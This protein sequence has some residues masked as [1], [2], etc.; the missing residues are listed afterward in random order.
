MTNGNPDIIIID[1]DPMVGELS[2]DLLTDEGYKVILIQD[3]INAIDIV[4]TQK[5]RLVIS[6]IMMPGITGMDICKTIKSDPELKAI[7][8]I[9]VSGKSYQVEKQRAFQFGADFFLQKPYNVETFSKTVKNILEETSAAPSPP[10]SAPIKGGLVIEQEDDKLQASDLDP[11]QIRLTIWGA[12][13]LPS[14]IPNAVSKYGR[15]TSCVSVETRENIFVFDA[16][17]GMLSLGKDIATRKKYYK[18]IWV[19]L[20][21]FHLD[22]IL[23]FGNFAPIHD[24]NFAIHIVGANDPERTLR[25]TAQ[26]LFY[27]SYAF[28]K[29]PPHAK[30]D[31]YEVLEDNY[32]IMP[33]V[34]IATMYANHPTSTL[35][36]SL[37]ISGKKI[38]YS[39][40]SEIWGE[41]TALQDYDEKFGKFAANADIFIHDSN[42]DDKDYETNKKQGHSGLANVVEFAAEKAQAKELILFHLNSEYTDQALDAMLAAAQ[43]LIKTKGYSLQCRLAAES[44]TILLKGNI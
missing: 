42:Y 11:G 44:Q 34:K 30:I 28:T 33:G 32:E 43:T 5:P 23:G 31:L 38:V 8:V 29:S 18:E 26:S 41:A 20:S 4:R 9:I 15:Q 25:E 13:G 17:T 6:D 21:H 24:P 16:G 7:K 35:I 40:D 1:D 36:Y 37:E 14:A 10:P 27:S 22:H 39:P 3:S 12:R 2:R 19:F